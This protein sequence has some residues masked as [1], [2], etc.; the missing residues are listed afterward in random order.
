VAGYVS[1]Y[2]F[3]ENT[4][5]GP[6]LAHR[7]ILVVVDGLRLDRSR[8]MPN[9]NRLRLEGADL[10]CVSGIPSYSRPGRA[11]LMTGAPPEIHGA[12]TNLHKAAVPFDNLFRG[13]AREGYSVAI[14]GSNLWQSL[15]GADLRGASFFGPEIVDTRGAFASVGPQMMRRDVQAVEFIL[16]RQP[17]LGVLDFLALDYAAHEHGAASGEYARAANEADRLIGVLL[18][19]VDLFRT[20]LVVTADHG[21]LAEGGHGGDEPEVTSIPWVMA[22]RGVREA[23]A[24]R[25]R[26]IDV[27][28]TLAALTGLPIPGASEGHVIGGVLDLE[29]DF[30]QAVAER[31][32]AHAALFTKELATSLGV[33]EATSVE[34]ARTARAAADRAARLPRAVGLG[35]AVLALLAWFAWPR[36]AEVLVAGALGALLNDGLFRVLAAR[37]HLR[38]ALSAINHEEDLG[39]Y[40]AHVASLAALASAASLLVVFGVAWALGRNA[41]RLAVAALC[42]AGVLLLA[43]V[44]A[45]DVHQGLLAVWTIGDIQEGFSAYVGLLR[46]R[47]LGLCALLVPLLLLVNSRFSR[48]G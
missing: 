34:Q 7:T 12:T 15:F 32:A 2:R 25:G 5:V 6:G 9:L 20:L 31:E 40:F 10:E 14:A 21:H 37:E 43:R 13:A 45:V 46:L 38:L 19:R 16:T 11:S 4:R 26:Q 22:G 8:L 23:V 33:R 35:L 27:A 18:D 28:A 1:P 3:S 36:P 30:K 48:E 24:G 42:G 44:L 41:G 29:P 47:T 17:Q 39:A